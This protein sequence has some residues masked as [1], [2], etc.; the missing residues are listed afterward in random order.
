MVRFGVIGCGAIHSTHC[1]ALGNIESA[2]LSAV[3][4]TVGERAKEAGTRF[5]VPSFT[6][7]EEL[8]PLVDA[9]CI[10]VPSGLHA[11][12]GIR[13][14]KAGKHVV[15]EKPID[16]NVDAASELVEVC[17]KAIVK[18]ATISQHRFAEDI[19]R[20]RDAAQ[21]G[22]LGKLI[23]GDAYTKWYR[24]Q[25]Y[26]DSGAWRG[27]WNLDGGGC[28]M[29]Q[30]VHYVDMIQWIMGGVR[31]VQAMTRT[32]THEIEVEDISNALIEY[33]NGAVGVLQNSTSFY[34]GL[35]ERLE[36]HGSY[37]TVIIEADKTKLWDVDEEAAREG[38]YGK[39]VLSQ[40]APNLPTHG[41]AETG[42]AA[43]P[44][45][46]WQ[47]QHCLQ[48]EDFTKA[49]LD[50]RDPFVTGRAALEPLRIILAVY[51]SA[52]RQDQRI[53]LEG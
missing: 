39:G 42:A 50:D 28:L 53:E 10:C 22:E 43:D 46:I 45:A 41:N 51:E 21:G 33:K 1:E 17:E 47:E 44:S 20:L 25:A 34:P 12:I 19:Q 31:A 37:G 29:N 4:D 30:G 38:L 23:A 5:G 49:V 8:W 6:A 3:H 15:V 7:L 16:V 36:V 32:A 14:A 27:T 2:V 24:T 13:A 40:P 48:L 52:K 9:V 35:A 26:Y 18:L 11:E